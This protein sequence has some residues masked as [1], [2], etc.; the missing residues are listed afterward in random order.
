MIIGDTTGGAVVI[1]QKPEAN[2]NIQVG[3]VVDLWIGKADTVIPDDEQ[4]DNL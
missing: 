3:D 2:E 4:R 1:R